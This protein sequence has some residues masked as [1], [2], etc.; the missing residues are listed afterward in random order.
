M[1]TKTIVTLL[2]LLGAGYT[3]AVDVPS[4]V[5][6]VVVYPEGARVTRV[7]TVNLSRG[8]NTIRLVGLVSDIDIEGLQV[9]VVGNNIR[10]GQIK[11]SEEQT[12]ESFDADINELQAKIDA[13]TR[14][15]KTVEDSSD[16]ARLR[17]QFLKGIAEGYAKE[18]WLEGTRGTADVT[19]WQAALDL[20]QSG[21]EDA[22]KLIRANDA[23]NIEFGKDISVLMRRL[24]T[25]R[26]RSLA[27]SVVE[28]SLNTDT[29]TQTDVRLRY[30]QEDASWSPRYEA[31]LDSDSGRL[32]LLQQA[33]VFQ[34]TDEDWRSVE[35]TLSTSEPHGDLIAPQ[36]DSQFLD[37]QEPG[38]P[39]PRLRAMKREADGFANYEALEQIVVTGQR[40]QT[41]VGGFAVSYR[42]P[43]RSDI[44]ND[45]EEPISIDLTQFEFTTDLVT[46]VVPRESTQAYLAA[47]FT[48][49]ASLPLY[50]STMTVYVDGTYVG[51]TRMPTALPQAE[52]MLPMGQDR[53]VE[54]RVQ[55]QGG[56]RGKQG[57]VNKRKSEATDYLFE[58]INHRG[59]ASEVEVF[60]FYP[61]ARNRTIE[62]TVPRSAT[63]PDERDI[64][65]KPGLIVWRK[66]LDAGATWRIRHQYTVTYPARS[67]LRRN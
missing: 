31:R 47:R 59:L 12:R 34:E 51:E 24:K 11:L 10:L 22:N 15:K 30:N 66:T 37:L 41:D 13:L 4:R 50:G 20:L 18:A 48:Y 6:N 65:D 35:L 3:F 17:L 64:D 2:S 8:N 45:S 1:L 19:S 5:E 60:D 39:E 57:I 56:E 46:Q 21:S 43:G 42:V 9:E 38:P 23:K 52:L 33:E 14:D 54:I 44:T 36:L 62:V 61:V 63:T 55:T 58:I 16:A 25:L 49:D 26:G 40:A 29:A 7:A 67:V 32:Q 28:F 27:T 53:R